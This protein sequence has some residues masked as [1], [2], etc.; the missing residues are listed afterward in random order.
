MDKKPVNISINLDTTPIL[1]TDLIHLSA[2]DDGVIFHVL[3]KTGKMGD[4]HIVSRIGMS[5]VHA[6]KLVQNLSKLLGITEHD[7]SSVKK[8]N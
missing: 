1:Y 3:Q 4:L 5:R 7:P 2:N 6:K 8:Q